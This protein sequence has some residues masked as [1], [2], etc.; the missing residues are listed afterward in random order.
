M[1][2]ACWK[3]CRKGSAILKLSAEKSLVMLVGSVEGKS[4]CLLNLSR[5]G[6]TSRG[7]AGE[8]DQNVLNGTAL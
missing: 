2:G 1:W 7:P 5:N 6:A 3:D 8:E 4:V